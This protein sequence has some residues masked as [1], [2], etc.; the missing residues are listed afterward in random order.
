MGAEVQ[1]FKGTF[2]GYV[3]MKVQDF[4][5][6]DGPL[7]LF[8]GV[9]SN[10]QA[11]EALI[12][13][14]GDR[15]AICT[16]DVVAYCADASASVAL[17]R[18]SG[19]P[20]VAG[21]CERQIADAASDCG[22]GF[23]PGSTCE[24]LSRGWYPHAAAQIGPNDRAWMAALPDIGIFQQGERRYAVLHGGATANNRFLWPSTAAE[25]FEDEINALEALTGQIDGIVAGHSGIAFQRRLGDY[26]WINAGA[27]GMPPH[28]GR[29]E[30]RFAVLDRGDVTFER[31]S[32]DVH[33]AINA[34][35]GAGLVQG[36]DVAL[37]IGL[38][39]SEDILPDELRR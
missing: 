25:D 20:L 24:M 36:Y 23:G 19:W 15:P 29:P 32:Y 33:A 2:I 21:N 7:V 37:Q 30:T 14:I 28:D 11:L 8:G 27:V 22:C 39:P 31:L 5:R 10:F 18:Q 9:Y 35:Q 17:V 34:M 38:W 16:G 12:K 13:A 3:A 6:F 1:S 26:S 4:G